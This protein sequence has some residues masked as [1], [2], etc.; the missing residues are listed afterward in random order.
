MYRF[1]NLVWCAL[2]AFIFICDKSIA[3]TSPP[4]FSIQVENWKATMKTMPSTG[5]TMGSF[6]IQFEKT[7]L[8]EIR[9]ALTIGDIAQKGDAGESVY[10]LC[11]TN[12][13]PT[14]VER[15][16]I[17]ASGEMGGSEHRV[18]GVIAELVED[19]K[20]SSDCPLLPNK[21][22]PV[23]LSSHIWLDATANQVNRK[24]GIPSYKNR[25][26]QIFNYQGKSPG[27]CE[28]GG[29]DVINSLSI[30]SDKG[31]VRFLRAGQITSC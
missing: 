10:W 27:A 23:L 17:T 18:T 4:E 29:F 14:R 21:F 31:R 24:F 12:K 9:K 30:Q 26:W 22:K 8:F 15:I 16:W 5:I 20:I 19:E 11:Y 25:A 7:D 28:G 1:D 6:R 2:V 3:K 13:E